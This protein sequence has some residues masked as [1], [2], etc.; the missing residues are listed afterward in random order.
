M[1][2]GERTPISQG[3]D[4]PRTARCQR[5]CQQLQAAMPRVMD[6]FQTYLREL[7]ADRS[8]RVGRP[9]PAQGGADA[10]RQCVDRAEPH[11]CRAVQGN[12]RPVSRSAKDQTRS[13][14]AGGGMGPR[15]R[16]RRCER[17]ACRSAGYW[18]RG[19]GKWPPRSGRPWSTTAPSSSQ[20][21]KGGAERILN[22]DEI[23]SLLGFNLAD[24]NRS[25]TIPASARSSTRRWS[26]TSACRCWRSSS[27]GWCG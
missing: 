4:R 12:C 8:R 1:P 26:P 16:G 2:A 22:Q 24:V 27:T 9:L 23:D 14:R 7:R 6:A 3:Q 10:P 18:R 25:A 17:A 20:S 13:G 19:R 5:S 11:Q 15:A 21:A